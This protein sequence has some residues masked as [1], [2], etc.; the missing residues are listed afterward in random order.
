MTAP[1]AVRAAT[2]ATWWPW[3]ALP[4]AAASLVTLGL[5]IDL[6]SSRAD[7][8]GEAWVLV[9]APIG[10]SVV[11]AG[12]WS[13]RPHPHGIIRLGILYTSIG[14]A[15]GLALA[16]YEWAHAGLAGTHAVAWLSGWVW[17]LGTPPLMAFGLL[18]YPDG[19]LPSRR[20]WPVAALGGL[21]VAGLVLSGAF[22]PGPL[23]DHPALHNPVGFGPEPVWDV[24]GTASFP[25]LLLATVLG[26]GALAVRFLRA[27]RGSDLRGQIAGFVIA[28]VV[29]VIAAALPAD[30]GTQTVLALVAGAAL[31][32]TVGYAVL[33]HRLLDQRAEVAGLQRRVSSLTASRR[34]LVAEREDERAVLRRELHDGLGPS[35]AA[36]GL[37]LRQL[38]RDP[39]PALVQG[40][41]DEVQRAVGEVRRISAGLG[42]AALDDLGLAS[43]L[44]ESLRTLDRFGPAVS[45]EIE[46]LPP[47]PRAVEVATYRIAMEAATNAVRH[48]GADLVTVR[49]RYDDG[50]HL[51]VRDDGAGMAPAFTPGIGLQAM[52]ARAEE[53]GGRLD[54][55]SGRTGTSVAAWLPGAAS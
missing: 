12:I 34:E 38:G 17:A 40:L 7:I 44:R 20:W 51:R 26:L 16:S 13:T 5:S 49:V 9:P 27:P 35:L 6:V 37:G 1:D 31:P 43:A 14:L 39:D 4:T 47:L 30:S 21:G 19:N 54:V 28:A 2:V 46:A 25:V 50:V 11:A 8:E 3:L 32:S 29:L 53:L 18:L 15:C 36:I 22:A 48:A 42:P 24:V 45:V 33:R 52:R 23:V 10:F 55:D 41:A